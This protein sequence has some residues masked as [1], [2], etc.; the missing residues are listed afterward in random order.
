MSGGQRQRIIIARAALKNPD[1]LI[2]DEATSALDSENESLV[3]EAIENLMKGKTTIVIA[4]R[5]N[6]II[7][8]DDIICMKNG[9]VVEQGTHDELMQLNGE[10]CNL[11]KK[12]LINK[13]D[14]K[15]DADKTVSKLSNVIKFYEKEWDN[16]LSNREFKK[17]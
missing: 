4:H 10:Y 14:E 1:I 16:R 6:T 9:E 8:A 12:Q 13:N 15:N 2:L 5:L 11:I 17:P 3:K 7:N